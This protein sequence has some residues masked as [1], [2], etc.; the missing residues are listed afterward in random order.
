MAPCADEQTEVCT[1]GTL[2]AGQ[3]GLRP[4]F[5]VFG[6]TFMKGERDDKQGTMA[7]TDHGTDA[8]RRGLHSPAGTL[9]RGVPG[10]PSSSRRGPDI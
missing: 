8:A 4:C 1:P 9:A 2:C 5:E 10:K 7:G 3:E 6:W